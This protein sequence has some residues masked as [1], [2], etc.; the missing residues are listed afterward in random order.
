MWG[1]V[2]GG[3][4]GTP[5]EDPVL[6]SF[7]RCLAGDILCVWRRVAATPATSGPATAGASSAPMFSDMSIAPSP[8]PPPLSLTAAKELWIFWYGEEPDLSGLVSPELIACGEYI[9]CRVP[10]N[11]PRHAAPR[12]AA[13]FCSFRKAASRVRPSL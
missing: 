9:L 6:S 12:R 10:G 8:A 4:G 1:E 7:S 2:A 11:A 5:L 13:P 3:F